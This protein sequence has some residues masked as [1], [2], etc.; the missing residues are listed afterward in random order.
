M[1]S[2]TFFACSLFLPA[3]GA[4]IGS[5]IAQLDY[6]EFFFIVGLI[7]YFP[8]A[9]ILATL[10][11]KAT[12]FRRLLVLSA[13]APIAFAVLFAV[14]FEIIEYVPAMHL[15]ASE[16]AEQSVTMAGIAGGIAL[17]YVAASWILWAL[18]R[19]MHW[20]VNEFAGAAPT[21]RSEV[22]DIGE[23]K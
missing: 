20:V 17:G 21:H 7:P 14:F 18:C 8:L 13:L 1:N 22:T 6:L 4:V 11:F 16:V 2:R 23:V 9:I 15:T 19:R 5:L 12:S 3:I 10:V